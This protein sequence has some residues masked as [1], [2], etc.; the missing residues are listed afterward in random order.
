LTGDAPQLRDAQ[1]FVGLS[2]ADPNYRQFRKQ[3]D[4]PQP[5]NTWLTID[6]QPDSISSGFFD[7]SLNA[8]SWG[9][10]IP[11]SYHGGGCTFSFADGHGE[12]HKWKSSTSIYGAYYNNN[13][14]G[15]IK[16]FDAAGVQDYQWYV[17]RTGYVFVQSGATVG[18]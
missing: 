2:W 17:Q 16:A 4:V 6:E 13:T 1:T 18:Y 7:V 5:A 9:S 10:H 15:F 12:M 11:G 14:P 8:T 3:T